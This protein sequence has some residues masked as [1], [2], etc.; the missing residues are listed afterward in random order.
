MTRNCSDRR[1]DWLR[2]DKRVLFHRRGVSLECLEL[3]VTVCVAIDLL[4]P[5]ALQIGIWG[6]R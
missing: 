2:T 4:C 3:F 6:H 5:T 1:D